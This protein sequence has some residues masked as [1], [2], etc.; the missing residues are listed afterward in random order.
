MQYKKPPLPLNDQIALLES[1]GLIVPDKAR[2]THYLSNISYYRL[3]AYMMPFQIPDDPHH[4]FKPGTTFSHVLDLYIFD[5]ELRLLMLDAIE[6]IEVAFRT[7]IIYQYALS[8]GSHWYENAN[9]FR[10]KIY[11]ERHLSKLDDELSRSNE[12]FIQHY[13]GK[14]SYPVRPPA[15]MALEITTMG[16][17]SKF[18]QTLQLS[19]EKKNISRHFKVSHPFILESWIHSLSYARNI[20]AHHSRLWNRTLTIKPKL[21][22]RTT[23]PWLASNTYISDKKFYALLCCT[24]YLLKVINP[25]TSFKN[26]L[27][28][29]INKYPMADVSQMGFTVDW[30]AEPLWT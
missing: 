3:R 19:K 24:Y 27:K 6:R 26:N 10:D 7:Q 17:L 21:P 13:Y 5:R 8:F 14:Y 4:A 2:A 29:L 12:V 28:D 18:F 25:D 15:W 30:E 16:L 23:E 11:H 22:N 1:R 9:L 20:C